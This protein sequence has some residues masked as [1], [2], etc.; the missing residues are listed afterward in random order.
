ML[1][2]PEFINRPQEIKDQLTKLGFPEQPTKIQD[3]YYRPTFEHNGSHDF[4]D[5]IIKNS[6]FAV[7]DRLYCYGVIDSVEQFDKFFGDILI[8]WQKSLKIKAWVA[9]GDG[10]SGANITAQ[11]SPLV[12]ILMM[13][14]ILMLECGVSTFMNYEI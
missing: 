6:Y 13:K 8:T 12:S 14:N 10:I 4:D 11:V 1:I 2:N 3:G 9:G 7:N 5:G